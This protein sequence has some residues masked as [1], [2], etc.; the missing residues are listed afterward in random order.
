LGRRARRRVIRRRRQLHP[1]GNNP[2]TAKVDWAG[3]PTRRGVV[4]AGLPRD[5]ADGYDLRV[6]LLPVVVVVVL[7]VIVAWLLLVTLLWLNRPP[8]E[9]VLAALPLVPDVTRFVRSARSDPAM[10]GR[11]RLALGAL[12]LYLRS[13]IDLLPD[14][15]PGIGTVDDLI[16]SGVVLRRVARRIGM[17]ALRSHWPG[18]DADFDLLCQLAR[19]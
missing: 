12:L 5:C 8:L 13:P 4:R 17:P 18:S 1:D 7:V 3:D 9:Y 11:S 10:S 6:D 19:I 2:L 15:L 14:L 16:L